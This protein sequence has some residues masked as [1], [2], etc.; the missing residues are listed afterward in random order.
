MAEYV[1][2]ACLLLVA[3]TYLLYPL[4]LLAA[5][6]LVQVV[7]DWRYLRSRQDRRVV[8]APTEPLPAVSLVIPAYNEQ[9]RLPEK[10]VNLR[11]L[12]YPADRLEVIFVSDGSTDGT[13]VLLSREAPAMQTV[14]LPSRGGKANA[15]NH[16]VARASHEILVFSD[17][18]TLLARDAI[19]KLVRHFVEARVGV[20]CGALQFRATAESRGT[21]GVYWAYESILRL[22]EAR[23]GA[24]LTASGALYALRRGCYLPLSPDSLV[25]DLLIPMH[26]R[27][28]GYR[29][30][31]DPEAV[32]TDYA[33]A[34]V[35][36]E[37]TRR[38]RVAMGSFLVLRQLV[39][40]R[41]DAVTTFA[42]V[43]HKLLRWILPFLLIGLLASSALLWAHPLYRGALAVQLLFYAWAGLGFLLRRRVEGVRY[44]LFAYYLLA[45]H[46]AFL[47]GFI[48]VLRR[49]TESAWQR[50]N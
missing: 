31:Y 33:A 35:S 13:D 2:W 42:F 18:A 21:E 41:L 44:A 39:S 23:L 29:V 10:L 25:E 12:D 37:F 26:A 47:V 43:S 9:M 16:G 4:F 5:C 45:I 17:A 11:Q 48:R 22:M 14:V 49:R 7:R 3:H 1:F 36:G 38:V 50:V 30:L 34:T 20:V 32:G 24:T 8:A 40:I 6:S 15:L 19:R 27:R 28:L 46:L